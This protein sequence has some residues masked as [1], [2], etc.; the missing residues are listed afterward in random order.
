[1]GAVGAAIGLGL[2]D[3]LASLLAY[4]GLQ[5]LWAEWFG[6]LLSWVSYHIYSYVVFC[7]NKQPGEEYMTKASSM[8]Y[9]VV[10]DETAKIS[11]DSEAGS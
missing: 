8:Y 4:L 2:A 1:M 9:E 10:V 11:P 6:C 7:I 5:G 3:Y